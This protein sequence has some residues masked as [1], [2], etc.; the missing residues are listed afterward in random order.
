MDPNTIA[1]LIWSKSS[2]SDIPMMVSHKQLIEQLRCWYSLLPQIPNTSCWFLPP[3]QGENTCRND[4]LG[5]L[6]L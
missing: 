4:I 2:S 1:F 5:Y 3:S 6:F